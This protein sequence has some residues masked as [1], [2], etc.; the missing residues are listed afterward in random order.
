M[1]EVLHIRGLTEGTCEVHD[2]DLDRAK[3][4]LIPLMRARHGKGGL[5][6][7]TPCIERLKRELE[8]SRKASP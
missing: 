8:E 7:C 6:V 4:E 2:W 1:P 3:R 5:N